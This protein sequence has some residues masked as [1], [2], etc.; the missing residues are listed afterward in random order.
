MPARLVSTGNGPS[1]PLDKP[2]VLLG[3]QDECDVILESRKVSRKHCCLAM[4]NGS[5]FIR[6]LGSTNGISV[7]GKRVDSASLAH[8]DIVSIGG[9][10]FELRWDSLSGSRSKSPIPASPVSS[11][12]GMDRPVPI[13]DPSI[14]SISSGGSR[15]AIA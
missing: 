7:N 13:P 3:R 5:V 11:D 1:I 2:I 6:D 12:S 8:G 9:H 14:K 15:L 10:A 4:I